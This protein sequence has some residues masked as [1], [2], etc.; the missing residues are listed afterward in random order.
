MTEFNT[1]EK[2][3][4]S[5]TYKFVRHMENTSCQPT[6]DEKSIPLSSGETFPPC[7]HCKSGAVWRN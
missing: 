5:G 7:R 4:S 6:D 2:A 3:P 1:G